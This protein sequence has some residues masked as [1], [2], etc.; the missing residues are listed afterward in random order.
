MSGVFSVKVSLYLDGGNAIVSITKWSIAQK[1]IRGIT[2][3][4]AQKH[5]MQIFK[6]I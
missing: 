6:L 5:D 1:N 4:I 3:M 2:E